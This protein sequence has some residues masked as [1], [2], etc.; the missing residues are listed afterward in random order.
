[1]KDEPLITPAAGQAGAGEREQLLGAGW[2]Q[3]SLLPT[4]LYAKVEPHPLA[5]WRPPLDPACWVVVIS[6]SCDI[7]NGSAEMEPGVEVVLLHPINTSRA[8]YKYLRNPRVLHCEINIPDAG[9][10][11]AEVRVWERGFVLRRHLADESPREG[12]VLGV[13][14]RRQLAHFFAR[15]YVRT[16]L[17][18][19]FVDRFARIRLNCERWLKRHEQAIVDVRV[20]IHTTE[21]TVESDRCQ[22]S[23]YV[24]LDSEWYAT[25]ARKGDSKL[26]FG[27]RK[28]MLDILAKQ[29]MLELLDLVVGPLREFDGEQLFKSQPLDLE[30]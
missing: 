25:E 10:V 2:S 17:P 5:S 16:A 7:V 22:F 6:Q 12:P 4:T 20:R 30:T 13:E 26:V 11:G 19:I 9:A 21:L 14:E 18:E 27:M 1:M 29:P 3:G 23:M 8:E 24:I 15:R 28:E